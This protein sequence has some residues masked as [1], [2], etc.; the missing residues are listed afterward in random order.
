M[1]KTCKKCGQTKPTTEFGSNKRLVDGLH[2]RCK[3]CHNQYQNE[4]YHKDPRTA[5]L[6]NSQYNKQRYNN[7]PLFQTKKRLAVRFYQFCNGYN[8]KLME[9][10]VGCSLPELNEFIEN[11]RGNLLKYQK[12]MDTKTTYDIDHI[13]PLGSAKTEEELLKLFHHSNLQIIS[14]HEN[15]YIKRGKINI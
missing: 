14:S 9:Q 3:A 13:I 12:G 15:R 6:L 4:T 5:T 11:N 8:D 7:D 10:L 2:Y 1:E